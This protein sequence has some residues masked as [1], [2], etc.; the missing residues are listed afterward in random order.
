MS[1]KVERVTYIYQ[2]KTPF[3]QLALSDIS[4]DIKKGDCI[5]IMGKSGSGKS[6]L[7]QLLNGLLKP[8]QGKISIDGYD[9]T[10]LSF[11]EMAFIRRKVGLV[12]QFPEEQI[13]EPT[14]YDEIGFTLRYLGLKEGAYKE[15]I[16][17]VMEMV[18]LDYASFRN[19]L[20]NT[21]SSGE[22]RRV[23]LAAI[24]ALRPAYLLLDEPTAALDYEGRENIYKVIG[25]LNQKWDTT[26]IIVSHH[27][28]HL[29]NICNRIVVLDQGQVALDIKAEEVGGRFKE[30]CDLGIYPPFHHEVVYLLKKRGWD[31]SL[32]IIKQEE[33]ACEIRRYLFKK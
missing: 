32:N 24:L 4:L 8:E 3:E 31:I 14:V 1:I 21:L 28:E 26:V 17:E 30:L 16:R 29:I 33:A 7:L 10:S 2:K 20:P 6:T 23:G 11:S 18:G 13:F 12:F 15:R 25:E 27:L 5:G 22:K 9:I 19:R